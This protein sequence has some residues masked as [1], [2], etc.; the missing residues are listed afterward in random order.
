MTPV[1][2]PWAV[3][4]DYRCF[5]CSPRNGGGM[6]LEFE[7]CAEGLRTRF[8]LGRSYESYPGV[9]HGGLSGVVCDETMGNLLVL[10]HGRSG[11]TTSMR[12]RYIAPLLVGRPYTCVARLGGATGGGLFQATA[13]IHDEAGAVMVSASAAYQPFTLDEARDRLILSDHDAALL[14]ASLSTART[15]H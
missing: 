13:D 4:D 11:F 9:V 3:L 1:K 14:T 7:T 2:V 5:G 15:E 12:L 10:A 8:T 6:R